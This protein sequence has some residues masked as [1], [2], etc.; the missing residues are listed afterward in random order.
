MTCIISST[1]KESRF[2]NWARGNRAK[3][4]LQKLAGDKFSTTQGI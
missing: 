3:K 2:S 1:E 4:L